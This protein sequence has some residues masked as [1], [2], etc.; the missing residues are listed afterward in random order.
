MQAH[1]FRRSLSFIR[2]LA[3]PKLAAGLLLAGAWAGAALAQDSSP[4]DGRH[5]FMHSACFVCHGEFGNGGVGPR[6]RDDRFLG[7]GDYVIALILLGRSVMPPFADRLSD[8]QIAA[9]A[10]YIRNSWGNSFGP[11][12]PNRVAQVRKLVGLPESLAAGG[13]SQP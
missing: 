12:E 2:R 11:V 7:V 6:F 13:Q 10:A 4:P 3:G 8:Q 9:V 1:A 5:V